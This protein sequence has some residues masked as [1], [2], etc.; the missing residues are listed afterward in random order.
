MA[1]IK[2]TSTERV[3]ALRQRESAGG[4]VR[5]DYY[6]TPGEHDQLKKLLK[7]LRK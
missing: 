6:A 1:D 5:R 7:E 2:K 4:R 3:Q